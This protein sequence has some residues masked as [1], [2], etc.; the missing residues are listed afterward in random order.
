MNGELGNDAVDDVVVGRRVRAQPE[1]EAAE[2]RE[3]LTDD[4]VG[5]RREIIAGDTESLALDGGIGRP[6]EAVW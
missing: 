6:H 5:D 3:Q 1:G 4:H 2:E